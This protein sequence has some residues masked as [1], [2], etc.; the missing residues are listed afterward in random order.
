MHYCLE[1]SE[2]LMHIQLKL[3]PHNEKVNNKL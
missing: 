3:T 1:K 2:Q